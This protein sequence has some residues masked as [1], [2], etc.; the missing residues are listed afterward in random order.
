M[1]PGTL[2]AVQVGQPQF[3][4]LPDGS[5]FRTSLFKTSVCESVWLGAENLEGNGQA[6]L[7]YHGGPDKAVCCYPSEHYPALSD[8]L[9]K[10]LSHGALGENFTLG[11]MPE[12]DVCI[13]DRYRVGDAIIE[14]SQPRQPCNTLVKRW[15][16]KNLPKHMVEKGWTGFYARVVEEGLVQAGDAIH[17]IERPL[18]DWSIT[19]L[20]QIMTGKSCQDLALVAAAAVLPQLSESWRQTL[21]TRASS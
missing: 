4:D 7:K 15:G 19:L 21:V 18:K 17:L 5:R 9:G 1:K 20:N 16:D 11:G 8:L 14:I 3:M 6:N 12:D 2:V 10:H 13:G